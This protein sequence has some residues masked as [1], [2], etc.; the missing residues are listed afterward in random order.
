MDPWLYFQAPPIDVLHDGK[1]IDLMPIQLPQ[2]DELLRDA[3]PWNALFYFI[4]TYPFVIGSIFFVGLLTCLFLP[5]NIISQ[6]LFATVL[7]DWFA[8]HV[9]AEYLKKQIDFVDYVRTHYPKKIPTGD[10]PKE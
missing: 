6:L 10:G 9:P 1:L 7:K 3:V 2:E 5:L 4:A 8:K